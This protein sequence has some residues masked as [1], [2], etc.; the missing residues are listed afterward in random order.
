MPKVFISYCSKDREFVDRLHCDLSKHGIETW[1][2]TIEIK[3]GEEIPHRISQG[4]TES[5]FVLVVFSENFL[6]SE[7]CKKEISSAITKEIEARNRVVLPV[8]IDQCQ[9]PQ[10]PRGK[11]YADFM[12]W[13]NDPSK[14]QKSLSDLLVAITPNIKLSSEQQ[15]AKTKQE[16]D[17]RHLSAIESGYTEMNKI[18]TD[19]TVRVDEVLREKLLDVESQWIPEYRQHRANPSQQKY[20]FEHLRKLIEPIIGYGCAFITKKDFQNLQKYFKFFQV[21]KDLPQKSRIDG[22]FYSHILDQAH[23][24]MMLLFYAWSFYAYTYDEFKVMRT[25]FDEKIVISVEDIKGISYPLVADM[26]VRHMEAF[27]TK[28]TDSFNFVIKWAQDDSLL[29]KRCRD[30]DDITSNLIQVDFLAGLYFSILNAKRELPNIDTWY[31]PN[32]RRF[33]QQRY[34]S[35]LRD[36]YHRT[37]RGNAILQDLL[38]VDYDSLKQFWST[39]AKYLNDMRVDVLS[40]HS[41]DENFFS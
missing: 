6:K 28:A 4:I 21:L 22:P 34:T 10:V 30:K 31:Y 19:S 25:I 37:R 1:I 5:D 32:F 23:D 15:T 12:D 2:D 20:L 27:G 18:L 40:A 13:Q 14:Y 3:I 8:K 41:L 26:S 35:V 33:Y 11:K 7:W 38:G 16:P 29:Q 36:V 17:S 9:I 24:G 39:C